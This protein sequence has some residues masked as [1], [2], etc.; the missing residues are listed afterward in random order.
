[1]IIHKKRKTSHLPKLPYLRL[2]FLFLIISAFTALT[3]KVSTSD[4]ELTSDALDSQAL[5]PEDVDVSGEWVGTMTEDYSG[6]TRYD[7]RLVLT[8]DGTVVDGIGYQESTN[9]ATETYAESIL[10]GDVTADDLYYYETATNVLEGLSLNRW[11][12][13]EVSLNYQVIEG[14]ETLIGTWGVAPDERELC[15]GIDGRVLLTRQED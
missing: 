5:V 9:R 15:D 3:L 6:E 7:Y 13:I 1:M 11:C 10:S 14:Q 4:T 8:Q 12:R 2:L